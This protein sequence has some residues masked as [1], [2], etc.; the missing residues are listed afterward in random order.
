ML[1]GLPEWVWREDS[2]SLETYTLKDV[3]SRV[4]NPSQLLEEKEVY[5]RIGRP[6]RQKDAISKKML[7][8]II[9]DT[10]V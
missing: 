8:E 9:R 6:Y 5:E 3:S 10:M 7:T 1:N 2:L 4:L